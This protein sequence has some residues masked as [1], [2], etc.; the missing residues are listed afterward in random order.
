MTSESGRAHL[1]TDTEVVSIYDTK[2]DR[3]GPESAHTAALELVGWN[4]RV[5]EVG[6]AGGHVTTALVEQGCTVVGVEID[7]RAAAAAERV[8]E[9]V[10]VGDI[11]AGDIWAGLEGEQFDAVLL[12]DVLEH[13]RDPLE[14]L[15]RFT[16]HLGPEG[17]V[18]I[19]LPNIAHGDV[20]LSLLC[21]E[22]TYRPT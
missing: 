15:R 7:P 17:V 5:L 22:F 21:G 14:A 16:T 6:C 10:V 1:G 20:R 9:H 8:A 19:S 11:D 18:V 13:L 12:G 3:E 2:V 4:K